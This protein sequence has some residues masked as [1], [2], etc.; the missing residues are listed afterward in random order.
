MRTVTTPSDANSEPI[1][2]TPRCGNEWA[3]LCVN[4]DTEEFTASHLGN[5]DQHGQ[6]FGD[7]LSALHC[8][9]GLLHSKRTLAP[10]TRALWCT[11]VFIVNPPLEP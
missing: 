2:Q 11:Q 10:S 1:T 6:R 4:L 9:S 8:L 5:A 3:M 7:G